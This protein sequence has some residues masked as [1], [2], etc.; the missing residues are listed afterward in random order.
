MQIIKSFLNTSIIIIIVII[1]IAIFIIIIIVIDHEFSASAS[2]HYSKRTRQRFIQ[3]IRNE[4]KTRRFL[5][6]KESG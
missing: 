3:F 6:G 4:T 2:R 5:H 1:I